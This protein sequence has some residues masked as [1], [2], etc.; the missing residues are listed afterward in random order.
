MDEKQGFHFSE[1]NS[2]TDEAPLCKV[3]KH[4]QILIL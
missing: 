3:Y 2:Q 1:F 4:D